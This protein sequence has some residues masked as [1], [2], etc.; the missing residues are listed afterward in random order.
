MFENKLKSISVQQMESI[1]A[2]AISDA[3]NETYKATIST[4]DYG[5]NSWSDAS[6]QIELR[7][8]LNLNF[9]ENQKSDDK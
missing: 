7:Q 1:I 6:F 4:I 9:G 5:K 8:P 2:K 3:A